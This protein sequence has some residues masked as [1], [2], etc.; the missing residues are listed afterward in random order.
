MCLLLVGIPVCILETAYGQVLVMPFH[1]R[2]NVI[3]PRLFGVSLCQ[4]LVCFFTMVYYNTLLAWC[5]AFLYYSMHSPLPWLTSGSSSSSLW[6]ESFFYESLLQRS[7]SI[8]H[9]GHVVPVIIICLVIGYFLVFLAI[10]R[11]IKS[12]SKVVYVTALAPYVFLLFLLVKG[13][14]LSGSYQGIQYLFVPEWGPLFSLKV[15]KD[16]IVQVMYSSGVAFGPLMFYG[17]CKK[18]GSA[19]IWPAVLVMMVNALTSILAA[20]VLFSFLGH[21]SGRLGVPIKEIS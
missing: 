1:Q 10:S 6:N 9:L 3:H 21:V 5:L 12:S 19:V 2:Y 13:M 16:S 20:V 7:S 17:S 15:W 8:S 18:E 11:G 4:M 14:S